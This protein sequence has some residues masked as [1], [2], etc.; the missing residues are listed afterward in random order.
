MVKRENIW[1]LACLVFLAVCL[2]GVPK[3]VAAHAFLERS[4]PADN[5]I[6]SESPDQFSLWFSEPLSPDFSSAQVLDTDGHEVTLE[7][8]VISA[9]NPRL[10]ILDLPPDLPKGAYSISWKV[11]ST[12]DGH[13][14]Q[15]LVVFGIGSGANLGDAVA[16][17]T[18]TAVPIPEVILRWLNFMTLMSLVGS[19]AVVGLVLDIYNYPLMLASVQSLARRRILRFAWWCAAFSLLAGLCWLIWQSFAISQTLPEGTTFW[20]T[21]WQWLSRTRLGLL[22]A[23]K[24]LIV[25]GILAIL[26]RLGQRN[27]IPGRLKSA[28]FLLVIAVVLTQSLSSHAAALRQSSTLAL[29]VDMLHFIAA[30]I[31]VGGLLATIVGFMP[32][33]RKHKEDFK[34]LMIAGW[35]PFG[36]V[37]V[38]A[39]LVLIATGLYSTGRQ[40][41]SVDALISTAYGQTISAK[42][43]L[44]LIIGGIGFL[45]AMLMH[46]GLA[47]PI[48]KIL[49]KPKGWTPV[50]LQQMP[51]LVFLEATLGMSVFV[52]T[53]FLTAAPTARGPQFLPASEIATNQ[54]QQIDDV[55]VNLSIKPNHPGANVFTIRA[56]NTRR[57]PLAEID[58]VIVRLTYLDQDFGM[59]S[60]MAEEVEPG[61]Y[62]VGGNELN[63]AGNW[64]VDVVVRR[65][66]LP[67]SVANF[68]WIVEDNG[69]PQAVIISNQD[70]QPVL[71]ALAILILLVMLLVIAV[72][73]P[74]RMRLVPL[75]KLNLP[76]QTQG[77]WPTPPQQE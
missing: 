70:W 47:A 27:T 15:G 54:N 34:L 18:E 26:S 5:A 37:A 9:E 56:A 22:W 45:N 29:V 40:V 36:R 8:I 49:R 66:G 1:R 63:V 19:L 28:S 12:A 38:I 64:R 62:R 58:R 76:G 33:V 46:S 61:V 57:P 17:E 72:L 6:L 7:G 67:D 53:S 60:V 25:M 16:A 73:M 2:G 4:E 42:L 20:Q 30:S 52:L 74:H 59:E 48:A 10:M 41:A 65:L 31:W 14:T 23:A 13:F 55:L 24:Q 21:S 69:A 39:V 71:S 50:P 44:L 43:L 3:S 77:L 35:R 51:R 32:I 11:L 75:L 68:N